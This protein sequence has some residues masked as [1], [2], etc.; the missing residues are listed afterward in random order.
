MPEQKIQ[1]TEY[2]CT[3]CSY[4]WITRRNG[5]ESDSRPRACARCKSWL[6]DTPRNND[7]TEF[8]KWRERIYGR[9]MSEKERSAL[10]DKKVS[11]WAK[12]KI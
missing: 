6:W 5:K 7:M 3:R 1:T 8:Y 11:A 2:W 4:K 10:N 9:K 12:T